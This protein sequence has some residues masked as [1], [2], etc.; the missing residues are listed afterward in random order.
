[1]IIEDKIGRRSIAADSVGIGFASRFSPKA[2]LAAA[3]WS[4]AEFGQ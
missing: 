2:T 1:M 4:L 3:A